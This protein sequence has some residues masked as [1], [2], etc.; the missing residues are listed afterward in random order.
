MRRTHEAV[1]LVEQYGEV[2]GEQYGVAP[3]VGV[4]GGDVAVE[5]LAGESIGDGVGVSE[6]GAGGGE[7]VSDV[8]TV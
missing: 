8:V 3:S 1:E 2:V 4:A 7:T 5:G 6:A